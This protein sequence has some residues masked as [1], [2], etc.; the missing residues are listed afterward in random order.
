MVLVLERRSCGRR[1]AG[2]CDQFAAVL[3]LCVRILGADHP[4]T[5]TTRADLAYWTEQADINGL[6]NGL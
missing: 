2:A 4:D 6:G 3:A 1:R 5:Q